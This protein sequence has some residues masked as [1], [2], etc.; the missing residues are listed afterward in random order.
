MRTLSLRRGK[1]SGEHVVYESLEEAEKFGIKAI[2]PWFSPEVEPGDW[3]V[4]DDGYVVQCLD[5]YRLPNKRSKSGQYTDTLRFPQGTFWVYYGANGNKNIKNFYAFVTNNNKSSLGNTPKTGR[6]M[7]PKK[8]LFV[9][10]IKRRVNPI[11]AYKRAFNIGPVPIS[12]LLLSINR[13]LSEE[14]VMDELMISGQGLS[15]AVEQKINEV[16]GTLS[17]KDFV[18]Y[19]L[20]QLAADPEASNKEV[21][22]LIKYLTDTFPEKLG[23]T[24]KTKDINKIP[25]TPYQE[26][27]PPIAQLN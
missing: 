21:L 9:E 3:V 16:T 7:T 23:I 6:F 17:L 20:A 13:L 5:R 14:A 25:D 10:Y 18:A 26:V 4:S 8:R 12:S 2:S 11:E 15:D 24:P 22:S 1:Y 27:K 19:K